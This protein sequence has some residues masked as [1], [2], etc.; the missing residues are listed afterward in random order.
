MGAS[1]GERERDEEAEEAADEEEE[2]GALSF[3]T[4]EEGRAKLESRERRRT[5]GTEEETPVE[6]SPLLPSSFPSSSSPSL[7]SSSFTISTKKRMGRFLLAVRVITFPPFLTLTSFTSSASSFASLSP[8][9]SA[10]LFSSASRKEATAGGMSASVRSEQ[11][12]GVTRSR[13]GERR[14]V[15]GRATGCGG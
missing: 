7:F 14:I 12:Y 11:T 3:F 15:R 2:S 10:S 9:S 5:K 1:D 8:L 4:R 13:H 6:P